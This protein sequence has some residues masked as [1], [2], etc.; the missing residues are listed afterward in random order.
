MIPE[1]ELPGGERPPAPTLARRAQ[2]GA[3]RP[4]LELVAAPRFAKLAEDGVFEWQGYRSP[5]RL[6]GIDMPE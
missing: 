1:W 2:E 3:F 5:F 4:A 6:D